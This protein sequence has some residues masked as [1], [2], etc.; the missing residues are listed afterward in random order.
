MAASLF[1]FVEQF[2]KHWIIIPNLADFETLY[3]KQSVL[4]FDLES[5]RTKA[6]IFFASLVKS[7]CFDNLKQNNWECSDLLEWNQYK[8]FMWLGN[9][10]K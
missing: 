6:N 2:E 4:F 5:R 9:K 7:N 3:S 8:I 10:K 1:A